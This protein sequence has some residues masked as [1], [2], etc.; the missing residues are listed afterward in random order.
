MASRLWRGV[1]LFLFSI[2]MAVAAPSSSQAQGKTKLV[3]AF[4][5][6]W[7]DAGSF[8]NGKTPFT[9]PQP[10]SSGNV[11]TMQRQ[12]GQA[13]NAGID[14]FIQ[15]WYGPDDNNYTEINF[16]ALLAASAASGFKVALYFES[17]SPFHAN[18]DQR[19]IALRHAVNNHVNHPAYLRIDGKPIIFF[20]ANWLFSVSDWQTIRNQVD[21]NH[22]TLWIAEG[23]NAEY[24]SVFDGLHLYNIAWAANPYSTAV[25][26]GNATRNASA[27]YGGYKYWAATA[28]PGWD[29]TLVPGRGEAAF[30]KK[31]DGG[32][33]Y[34]RTFEAAASSAPDMLLITSFNEW[35]EGSHIE[36]SAEFGNFYLDLTKQYVN[37]FKYGG[38]FSAPPAP[39]PN[40]QQP[41]VQ[42]T[43]PPIAPTA[44]NSSATPIQATSQAISPT[45]PAPSHQSP[46][47][48]S[49]PVTASPQAL[50]GIPVAQ[51]FFTPTPLADGRIAYQAQTGDTFISIAARFDLELELLYAYNELDPATAVLRLGQLLTIGFAENYDRVRFI[52]GY[53]QA[54]ILTDGKVV[55]IVEAGDTLFSIAAK[56][57]LTLEELY[58]RSGLNA[59]SFLLLNQQV[60]VARTPM[61]ENVGGSTDEE[62]PTAPPTNTPI[63]TEIVT[64]APTQPIT[65]SQATLPPPPSPTLSLFDELT[66]T[67]PAAN[68]AP[69]AS[70]PDAAEQSRLSPLFIAG[71]G[72][73]LAAGGIFLYLGRK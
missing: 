36:P 17:G 6:A 69:P 68:P 35:P 15:A 31:R 1:V 64:P 67:L 34:R 21:P 29:D 62:T 20:W 12:I 48:P 50:A 13:K 37:G 56:N 70:M 44:N 16:K 3:L 30:H 43:I 46:T 33:F 2:G 53:P 42:P 47:S 26:W 72:L 61:P 24:L 54:R 28:M 8:N 22:N 71:I 59:D 18:H 41:V 23:G 40:A 7:Y 49:Q 66:A 52:P 9:N 14:A 60:V 5:Y 32:D 27:T 65:I 39:P 55:H 4:Y 19:A 11:E 57:G 58:Q 73:L 63:P 25:T 45:P 10:Y 51:P 38:G